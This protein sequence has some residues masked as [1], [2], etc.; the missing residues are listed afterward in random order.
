MIDNIQAQSGC[1]AP[2]QPG[3]ADINHAWFCAAGR[4]VVCEKN[5]AC[6]QIER[7][8]K[9]PAR[10]HEKLRSRALGNDFL[11]YDKSLLICKNCEHAF[12]RQVTHRHQ[13]I[14]EK[15]ISVLCQPGSHQ[16]FPHSI[17]DQLAHHQQH[18]SPL[19]I[20]LR[21]LEELAIGCLHNPP[22]I[23]KAIK[24]TLC[25]SVRVMVEGGQQASQVCPGVSR[26][27]RL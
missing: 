26:A 19:F 27:R 2:K 14:G 15:R 10:C 11:S 9:D 12:L 4:V 20:G 3:V 17:M 13:E 8:G 16:P 6:I 1:L 5:F 24:Q 23:T 22:D 25:Q 7:S 21:N 18:V